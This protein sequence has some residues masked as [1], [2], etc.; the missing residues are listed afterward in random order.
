[1]AIAEAIQ[2]HEGNGHGGNRKD[3]NRIC[4][5]DVN[6]VAKKAGFSSADT[7]ERARTVVSNGTPELVQAMDSGKVSISA[8]ALVP[9]EGLVSC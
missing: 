7:F 8:F 5:L 2:K 3:Q 4:G 6:E 9:F 1:M